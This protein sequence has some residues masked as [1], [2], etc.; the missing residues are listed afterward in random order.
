MSIST[1]LLIYFGAT[2]IVFGLTIW[3]LGPIAVAVV[4]VIATYILMFVFA[5]MAPISM[6]LFLVIYCGA[7]VLVGGILA[8]FV[9]GPLIPGIIQIIATYIL[10]FYFM[11]QVL[12]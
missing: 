4:N 6:L 7:T 8:I 3:N 12:G 11:V 10:M 9:T 2:L 5:S 1:F